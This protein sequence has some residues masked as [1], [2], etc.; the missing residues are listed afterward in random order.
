M[1]P[2]TA[3]YSRVPGR[4]KGV[5]MVSDQELAKLATEEPHR[6][7]RFLTGLAPEDWSRP[8][9]C[10]GWLVADVAAHLAQI[11]ENFVVRL[12][13]G[14][15]GDPTEAPDSVAPGSLSEDEFRDLLANSAIS[16]RERMGDSLLP[17][18]IQCNRKLDKMISGLKPQDWDVP[19]FHPMGPEPVRTLM[20]MR[21]TETAMH[22]WDI[23]SSLDPEAIISADCLP[24]MM[25]TIPRAV[26]RAFR[27]S[28]GRAKAVRYRFETS[29][30]VTSQTDI[31]LSAEG[32]L[33]EQD[34]AGDPD[35]TFR[36]GA[37]TYVMVMFG[38]MKIGDAI[39]YGSLAVDGPQS[40]AGQFAEAF[41]GG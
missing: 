14:L 5:D 8:S 13:R 12:G 3:W 31:V 39:A 33:V 32:A 16:R 11:G 18:Y 10:E 26:R 22:S 17:S 41:V 21:V 35:V 29:G 1:P 30:A 27:P 38:R 40:L 36:C 9:A 19:C 23:R 2:N 15:K 4:S 34:A 20:T 28:P 7:E 24:A 25:I 37:D 6:L